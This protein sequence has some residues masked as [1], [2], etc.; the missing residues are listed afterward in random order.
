[1]PRIL[2]R[3]LTFPNS[4]FPS[5]EKLPLVSL[6]GRRLLHHKR[7]TV[8]DITNRTP[9]GLHAYDTGYM[10]STSPK[11]YFITPLLKV[12]G[13]RNPTP[14]K[15]ALK[16]SRTTVQPSSPARRCCDSPF[17]RA[18]S[19][20]H[21][22]SPIPPSIGLNDV[23]NAPNSCIRLGGTHGQQLETVTSNVLHPPKAQPPVLGAANNHTIRRRCR[24]ICHTVS[25]LSSIYHITLALGATLL[26]G[27]VQRCLFYSRSQPAVCYKLVLQ[28]VNT[29]RVHLA[30]L[31]ATT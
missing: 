29:D 30:W 15:W 16:R 24:D 25:G 3:F 18:Y 13:E 14:S 22:N 4:Y 10:L 9:T 1:M 26:A 2:H 7:E 8:T 21:P 20:L 17:R 28:S 31:L 27:T 23:N 19:F 5:T 11:P 6:Q 12:V